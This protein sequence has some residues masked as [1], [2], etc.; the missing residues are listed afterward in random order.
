MRVDATLATGMAEVKRR[1]E[2]HPG[3]SMVGNGSRVRYHVA[4]DN[5]KDH[6]YVVELGAGYM[7]IETYAKS[8][9]VY[10]MQEA[11]LRLVA[12]SSLLRDDYTMQLQSLFPYLVGVLA[13]RA[14]GDMAQKL[15]DGV[16]WRDTDILLA[17]KIIGLT[18]ENA[19]LRERGA[20]LEALSGKLL[21][22]MMIAK[23]S[24]DVTVDAIASESGIDAKEVAAALASMPAHGYRVVYS[25]EK[26]FSLVMA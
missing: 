8:S 18:K 5:E 15:D 12:I 14:L 17:K 25:G 6:F 19:C 20:K 3:L 23:Y 26:R 10:F 24:H 4:G 9:P 1:L 11:L 21:V 13:G 7:A 22:S 2:C 16:R